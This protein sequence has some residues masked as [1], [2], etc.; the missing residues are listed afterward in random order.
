MNLI[1]YILNFKNNIFTNKKFAL[2]VSLVTISLL[3]SYNFFLKKLYYSTIEIKITSLS[4]IS[5]STE[6]KFENSYISYSE[7]SNKAE[8]LFR[9]KFED[10]RDIHDKDKIFFKLIKYLK[11]KN[12]ISY[13]RNFN[14]I[15]TENLSYTIKIKEKNLDKLDINREKLF[16]K[17]KTYN[18]A[19]EKQFLDYLDKIIIPYIDYM[20]ENNQILMMKVDGDNKA[21]LEMENYKLKEQKRNVL[22]FKDYI[23]DDNNDFIVYK[24]IEINKKENQTETYLIQI[25]ISFLIWAIIILIGN[26]VILEYHRHKQ[27]NT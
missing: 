5:N 18:L 14:K 1:N 26:I 4:E 21:K 24:E 15:I 20:I 22:I 9:S 13:T 19:I 7:V 8:I 25:L 12:N 6:Y 23:K 17:I 11:E 3:F 10:P 27:E 16:T 2:V